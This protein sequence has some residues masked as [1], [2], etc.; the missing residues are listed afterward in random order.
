[1]GRGRSCDPRQKTWSSQSVCW[2]GTVHPSIPADCTLPEAPGRQDARGTVGA[3]GLTFQPRS[4]E[5]LANI[6]RI[7]PLDEPLRSAYDR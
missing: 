7:Y 5:T 4:P 1:M 2:A 3:S 6:G